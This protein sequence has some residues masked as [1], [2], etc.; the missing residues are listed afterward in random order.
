ME[1]VAIGVEALSRWDTG[2]RQTWGGAGGLRVWAKGCAEQCELAGREEP[3]S[4]LLQK[5]CLSLPSGE[6]AAV[7]RDYQV[8]VC[9]EKRLQDLRVILFSSIKM[10]PYFGRWRQLPCPLT[11]RHVLSLAQERFY[12]TYTNILSL[13]IYVYLTYAWCQQNSE[14][15]ILGTGVTTGC[16]PPRMRMLGIK[17]GSLQ[18]E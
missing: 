18:E 5:S 14:C 1:R 2:R 12:L 15:Q 10:Y 3:G 6:R 7:H 17:P 8:L 11:H 4:E 16:E 13:Y 9:E